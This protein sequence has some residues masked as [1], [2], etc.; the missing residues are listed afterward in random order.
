[1]WYNIYN[2]NVC[3]REFSLRV[4]GCYHMFKRSIS[5]CLALALLTSMSTFAANAVTE[6]P[7]TGVAPS[8][9][10]S[11]E[12]TGD[13]ND[14]GSFDVADV[15][16]LQKW[17]LAVPD[18]YLVN[19]RAANY[20]DDECLNV[21]DLCLMKRALLQKLYPESK[22]NEPPIKAINPTLP[23]LGTDR[24]PVFAVDFPDCTFTSEDISDK[25]Q[26]NFFASVG[27]DS[28]LFPKESI[29]A[30]YERSSYGKLHL[31]GDV[32]TY[33]AEH[34]ID[35]YADDDARSLVGEILSAYDEQLDYHDYDADND[36]TIDSIAIVLPDAA[37]EIDN[38]ADGKPDWWAFSTT[39]TSKEKYD[40]LDVGKYCLVVYNQNECSDFITKMAHELGHAMGLPDYYKYTKDETYE[41]DGLT[42]PAGNE[43]MDEGSG[44]LSACSKLLLGWL[45]EDQ[46]QVYSGGTQ[47]FSLT[48]MQYS[49]SCILIP[50]NPDDN[51]L[52]EYFLIEYV[53]AE[54]N[55]DISSGNGIR[56]LHVE[57]EVSE[58]KHG[59]ELTYNNYG[60]KYDKS[61]QKQRVL[62]L[63]NQ[64]GSFYP[65]KRGIQYT[66]LIDGS[67]DGFHWYDEEGYLTVDTGL[68]IEIGGLRP[69]PDFDPSDISSSSSD[70]EN[71][72][73]YI[74]GST[75]NITI[76]PIE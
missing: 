35:W 51:Y 25:L 16:L 64:Y 26:D 48:S 34:P 38:D 63:V 42:G 21:F 59:M 39:V 69:G 4:K 49:P 29:S 33:T 22:S 73:S 19:W 10:D 18:T 13:V 37:I 27:S 11:V 47:G 58:G 75:Y 2:G 24:I 46:I 65:G 17:L 52:S 68:K 67:I 76:S 45:S 61:N 14:D 12:A 66:N 9:G 56:I 30:Y 72:P 8:Q 6:N 57:A 70:F 1:M 23:S 74:K 43:L 36:K 54:A 40:E 3:L 20:C 32:F 31:T 62:R 50:K 44:D 55:N 5:L 60:Q 53:T 7:Q 41:N 71:D 15:V 28:E